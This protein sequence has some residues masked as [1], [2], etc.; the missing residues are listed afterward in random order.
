MGAV[1]AIPEI[2]EAGVDI[3]GLI[4]GLAAGGTEITTGSQIAGNTMGAGISSLISSLEIEGTEEAL[5]KVDVIK[6]ILK[7]IV[8]GNI[9]YVVGEELIE[10][11]GLKKP[12]KHNS[13]AHNKGRDLSQSISQMITYIK[14]NLTD[15]KNEETVQKV[16]YKSLDSLQDHQSQKILT[17]WIHQ[18]DISSTYNKKFEE[19]LKVYTGNLTLQSSTIMDETGKIIEVVPTLDQFTNFTN[20]RLAESKGF[21]T[22]PEADIKFLARTYNHLN[23]QHHGVNFANFLDIN[24]R[25]L[26]MNE[27]LKNKEL[28]A[29]TE[30]DVLV[31]QDDIFNFVNPEDIKQ[32]QFYT[33]TVIPQQE[34]LQHFLNIPVY[35]V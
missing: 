34:L 15:F 17:N 32:I 18:N 3:G 4:S 24:I 11:I 31:K 6:K 23:G 12:P 1:L 26:V 20:I 19:Y 33:P 22:N 13:E 5:S 27:M 9:S 10:K 16:L 25:S 35:R 30:K 14:M 28:K 21:I 8:V 7:D 29:L 2:A